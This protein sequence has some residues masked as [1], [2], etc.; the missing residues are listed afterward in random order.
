M[1][2]GFGGKL[3][4][5]VADSSNG[6]KLQAF[7]D[8]LLTPNRVYHIGLLFDGDLGCR[9]YVDG[10]L[11]AGFDGAAPNSDQATHSGDY[12]YGQPDGSLDTGGTD[13]AYPSF[14]G[15]RYNDWATWSDSGND[16]P[17]ETEIRVEI[18][19]KGA[20][21]DVS[22]ASDTAANMQLAVDALS[23]NSYPDSTFA[24]RVGKPSDGSDLSL[25][26]DN[27]TF[28]DRTSIQ[29]MWMGSIGSTLTITNLNGS[30]LDVAKCSTA[31]GG[32]IQV[33]NPATLSLTG[34]QDNTEIRVYEAGTTTEVA[35]VENSSGGT[36]SASIQVSSVDVVIHAL[37]FLADRIEGVDMSSGDVALPIQQRVDRQYANA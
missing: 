33:V 19:E 9:A 37:G 5:N 29:V 14:D 13:I 22:I 31:Y 23:G 36:F 6:F 4:C 24:I 12:A 20:V 15:S 34:L 26:F 16:V 35:G 18:F 2:I 30:N 3:L 8:F 7:S 1:V 21:E 10:V 28:G 32:A 17:S 25:D 11:Q 27:I